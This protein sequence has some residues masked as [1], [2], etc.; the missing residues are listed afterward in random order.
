MPSCS[1]G[2]EA[3]AGGRSYQDLWWRPDEPGWGVNIAHQG[4]TL[5]ATWFT[6]DDAGRGQWLV[7]SNASKVRDGEYAGK[8]YRTTGPAFDSSSWDASRV[9]TSELGTATFTFGDASRGTFAYTLDGATRTKAIERMVFALPA[10]V[11]N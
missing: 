9:R 4:D 6:Y 2:G 10:S 7:M 3:K 1:V 5:F 8:I 11:C